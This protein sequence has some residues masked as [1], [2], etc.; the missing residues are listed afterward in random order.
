MEEDSRNKR[1]TIEGE[2][3]DIGKI[4]CWEH[5]LHA[6]KWEDYKIENWVGTKS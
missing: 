5:R 2:S 6:E 1:M 4:I 3:V